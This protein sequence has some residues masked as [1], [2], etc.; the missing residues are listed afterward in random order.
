MQAQAKQKALIKVLVFGG[1][2]AKKSAPDL[3]RT[4]AAE[5]FTVYGVE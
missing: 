4:G 3:S 1:P 2:S 5:G